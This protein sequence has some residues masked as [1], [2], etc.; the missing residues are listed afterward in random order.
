MPV[1][2]YSSR[3]TSSYWTRFR[4]LTDIQPYLA[5]NRY[6]R[7]L[8]TWSIGENHTKTSSQLQRFKVMLRERE[9]PWEPLRCCCCRSSVAR[10][11]R[12][13]SHVFSSTISCRSR[14]TL[15]KTRCGDHVRIS[16]MFSLP[17][18]TFALIV[19]YSWVDG[20]YP[21]VRTA[22][23]SLKNMGIHSLLYSLQLR[24]LAGL[25]LGNDGYWSS[26]VGI[27]SECNLSD[28]TYESL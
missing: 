5:P 7:R 20:H 2:K 23:P 1:I 18:A 13:H 26:S 17:Q 27:L 21:Q 4:I 14:I 24:A 9:L 8:I 11:H 3:A 15:C 10:P 22:L 28:H 12:L 25:S 6:S 19:G 16:L